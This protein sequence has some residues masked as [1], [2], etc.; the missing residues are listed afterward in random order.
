[1]FDDL[2]HMMHGL[3][4]LMH[5]IGLASVNLETALAALVGLGGLCALTLVLSIRWLAKRGR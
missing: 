3:M 4:R 2:R 1:L 5:E